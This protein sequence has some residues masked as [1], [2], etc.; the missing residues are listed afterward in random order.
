MKGSFFQFFVVLGSCGVVRA[1]HFPTVDDAYNPGESRG[2][3]DVVSKP[4][5]IP[6]EE[7]IYVDFFF[8]IPDDAPEVFHVTYGEIVNSQPEHLHHFVLTGCPSRVDDAMD[9]VASEYDIMSN[10][11]LFT[12][13]RW[14]PGADVFNNIDLDSG[15][16]LGR[17]MGIEALQM[18]VHYT[19]GVSVNDTLK[20]ATDGIR[21]HYTTDFRPYSSVYKD[22]INVAVAPT[23]LTIPPNDPRFY[24]TRTCE[25]QSN[26][27]DTKAENIAMMADFLGI[28]DA[29]GD[30]SITCAT[31]LPF[32]GMGEGWIVRMC[33]ETCGMCGPGPDGVNRFDPGAYRVT[34]VNYHA[35]LLGREMYT[36][37]T[38]AGEEG[39]DGETDVV[40]DDLQSREFW[41]FDNQEAFPLDFNVVE[42]QVGQE[43]RLL[44][45]TEIRPG[46]RI[47]TTCVYD[48]TYRTEPTNFY[49]S[50]YDEMCLNSLMITFETPKSL[51]EPPTPD[52]EEEDESGTRLLDLIAEL[53]LLSFGCSD[54]EG[55]DVYHGSLTADEDGRDVWRDHPADKSEGCRYVTSTILFEGIT[56]EIRNCGE[57]GC[58]CFVPSICP[59]GV[60]IQEDAEGGASCTGGTLDGSDVNEGTTRE[61][62][63]SGGGVYAPYTC[64]EVIGFLGNSVVL[65]VMIQTYLIEDW[66]RPNCCGGDDDADETMTASMCLDGVALLEDVEAGSSC[67]GGLL[68]MRDSNDGTTR[69]ECE[70]GGGVYAP[71]TCAEALWYLENEPVDSATVT[72]LIDEWWSPICCGSE[73]DGGDHDHGDDHNGDDHD[74]G[75]DHNGD[76][77]DEEA[78]KESSSD[79]APGVPTRVSIPA[80]T[81][82]VAIAVAL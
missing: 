12:V 15:V 44:R 32:C 1:Q 5:P 49:L 11:C 58:D 79:A 65:D 22:L 76:D 16:L 57:E 6:A 3:F 47:Q 75:D 42:N 54:D 67:T 77:H 31:L 20:I 35:H 62:C 39:D 56:G 73:D 50:T 48:S 23:S 34:A 53:H 78:E 30:G 63:E 55:G 26:C 28:G 45:G 80:V 27:R 19:D 4:F 59:E 66:W 71:Y 52:D 33:P 64:G 68:N 51:L 41:I 36:T 61:D 40:V 60:A 74:H 43:E 9:G 70:S 37:L 25:V 18:N 21:V 2:S 14:A 38:H 7:T 46:D 17:G 24:L 10:E 69:E 72:F 81:A 13:G 82:L 29:A 8:N